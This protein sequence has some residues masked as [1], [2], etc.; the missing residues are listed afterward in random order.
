M[1]KLKSDLIEYIPLLNNEVK[2]NNNDTFSKLDNKIKRE[3][4]AKKNV[5]IEAYGCSAN[6]ADSEIIAGTLYSHGYNIVNR[7]DESDLNIIV[8]CSVKDS[9]EHTMLHRIRQLTVDNKPL[10]V[11]GCLTKT[12]RKKI[13]NINPNVSL[14]GPNSLDKSVEAID[15]TFS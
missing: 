4:N 2:I 5:W 12:E 9:T 3:R 10:I 1:Q 6:I 7:I 14:L 13:E 8:T 11:A 15:L